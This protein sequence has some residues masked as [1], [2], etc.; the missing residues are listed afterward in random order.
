MTGHLDDFLSAEQEALLDSLLAEQ[1]LATPPVS[2]QAD[3]EAEA[4]DTAAPVLTPNPADRYEPFPLTDIQQGYWLG[5][6]AGFELGAV[7]CYG[8]IEVDC[9]SLDP[10]RLEQALARVV[11]RHDM[12]RMRVLPSGEQQVLD[13]LPSP[14]VRVQD[15]SAL[16]E[17]SVAEHLG[18]TRAVMAQQVIDASRAPLFDIRVSLLPSGEARLH[19]GIDS[20]VCDQSSLRLILRDLV[21]AYQ[22][23]NPLSPNALPASAAVT[24]RDYVQVAKQLQQGP[25]YAA[26]RAYWMDRLDRL[27]PAPDL[28]RSRPWGTIERPT[29]DRV[30][31]RLDPEPWAAFQASAADHGVTPSCALAAAFALVL[32]RWSRQDRLTLNLT[33]F[34][35]QPLHPQIGEVVGDFTSVT[36]LEIDTT[37]GETSVGPAF[38]ALS[39]SVQSRLM[40]GIEHSAFSGVEVLRE[41]ARRTGRAGQ[42]LTPVVFTSMLGLGRIA[43]QGNAAPERE[44]PASFGRRGYTLSETP[45]VALDHH[46]NQRDGGL[47]INWDYCIEA[48][49]DGLIADMFASFTALV[50]ELARNPAAWGERLTP[51]LPDHQLARRT[52]Y[53]Q[54]PIL[55][56]PTLDATRPN[57][58]PGG[59]VARVAEDPGRQA[60]I[61]SDTALTYGVVSRLAESLARRLEE[62]GVGRGDKVIIALSKGWQQGVAALAITALGAAYA[63]IRPDTPPPR[64]AAIQTALNAK[65]VIALSE[66]ALAIDDLASLPGAPVLVMAEPATDCGEALLTVRPGVSPEDVAYVIFTSGSSGMPKGVVIDHRGALNTIDDVNHRFAIDR[67]DRVLAL[68]AFGFDLSVYDL[69]GVLAVGGAVVLPDADRDRDPDHWALMMRRHGVTLWNSVPA[70]LQMLVATLDHHPGETPLS[71][72]MVWLSGDWIPLDLPEGVRRHWPDATLISMGGATEASI[73]SIYYPVDAVDPS[74]AS[75]P[76][77]MPLG[78]QGM[79]VLDADLAPTPDWVTGEIYISGIGVAL[80]Y[81]SEPEKTAAQFVQQPETGE[82]LYRTGDLGRFHPDGFIEFMGREDQ[83]VKINGFRVELGEIEAALT[84]SPDIR[85]AAAVCL[86]AGGAGGGGAGA[87]SLAAFVVPEANVSP[88][89]FAPP[90]HAPETADQAWAAMRTAGHAGQDASLD[91]YDGAWAADYYTGLEAVALAMINRTVDR[92]GVLPPGGAAQSVAALAGEAGIDPRFTRLFGHWCDALA[93]AGWLGRTPEGYRRTAAGPGEAELSATLASLRLHV[94]GNDAL[95]TLL[96]FYENC[97]THHTAMLRGDVEPVAVLFDQSDWATS[98]ALYETQPVA[99]YLNGIVAQITAAAVSVWGQQDARLLEIGAGIGATSAA[100]LPALS[101]LGEGIGARYRF[102]DVSPVF[103]TRAAQRFAGQPGFETGLLDINQGLGAQEFATGGPDLVIAANVLHNA[104]DLRQCL[105]SLHEAI[106]PGGALM[107]VEGFETDHPILL[108]SIAFLERLND[109]RDD[110]RATGSWFLSEPHWRDWLTEAGFADVA[111]F[112]EEGH[113]ARVHGQAVILARRGTGVEVGAGSGAV[114]QDKARAWL[115]GQLPD[116]M[117]PAVIHALPHLPLTAN[118]KVDRKALAGLANLPAPQDSVEQVAPAGE[119]ELLL[120][121]IWKEGLGRESVGATQTLFSL[122]GD[123]L[124]AVQMNNRITDVFEVR[125]PLVAILRDPTI[126]GIAHHIEAALQAELTS[127]EAAQ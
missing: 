4:G 99:R 37:E 53:N 34:D 15:L 39:R 112:P 58:L 102:T 10:A 42:A 87:R 14:L 45:Q 64:F 96:A 76:Y 8:Y 27:A 66:S 103:L 3:T 54:A 73:W 117:V 46:L 43:A 123:S 55:S 28:P 97:H 22:S 38:G 65:A 51:A 36:L 47:D 82:R 32:R 11:A 81:Q 106:A 120:A 98:E 19:F 116:Y 78:G 91:G 101:G 2:T 18:E 59:F 70:L 104:L 80:G 61:T 105:T 33:L 95:V 119:I 111:V 41:L 77:G 62:L 72:R 68:S 1:G 31:T 108:A 25:A 118:G 12:M 9:P 127:S 122:G 49:P 83:Q 13:R 44:V 94:A 50:E 60:L 125:I 84:K 63:P 17:A 93:K 115:A 89:L 26:A 21:T 71:L 121:D 35:R 110:R 67:D 90:R 107:M 88:H 69:F 16:P 48:Y 79:H 6:G 114:D 30:E 109:V 85:D 86:T 57:T 40:E 52:A 126:A 23:P 29:F 74:W 5:R 7:S 75:I 20:L 92:L 124:F 56:G 113:P 24:F 100:V